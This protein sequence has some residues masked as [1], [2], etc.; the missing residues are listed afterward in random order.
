MDPTPRNDRP[1]APE[2]ATTTTRISDNLIDGTEVS[3]MPET[4][5]ATEVARRFADVLN[6]VAYRRESFV[7]VRGQ[8]PVAELRPVP[9][10]ARLADLPA[11]LASLPSLDDDADTFAADLEAARAELATR[12]A[13]DPWAS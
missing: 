2:T 9:A 8:R 1:P 3:A 10:G 13:T 12:E 6:R 5:T 11:L 7:I 4:L